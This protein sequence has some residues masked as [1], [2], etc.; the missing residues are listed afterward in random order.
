MPENKMP[1]LLTIGPMIT[2]SLT[3][4]LMGYMALQ[5]VLNNQ[6]TWAQ[7]MPSLIICF[8]MLAGV[9]IWP[10]L[11]RMYTKKMTKKQEKKEKTEKVY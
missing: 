7:A 2:M 11:T 9:I 4:L 3:S 5:N 8:A 6:V 1:L 10:L